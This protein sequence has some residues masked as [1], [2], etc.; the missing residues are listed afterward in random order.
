MC[1]GCSDWSVLEIFGIVIVYITKLILAT[2]EDCQ[3]CFNNYDGWSN[4]F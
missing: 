2:Y 1:I 4:T 3:K